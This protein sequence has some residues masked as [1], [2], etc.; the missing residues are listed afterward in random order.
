MKL[1]LKLTDKEKELL[2]K[3]LKGNS[4][5]YKSK[6]KPKIKFNWKKEGF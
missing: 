4:F 5:I 3:M 1:D 6:P 2:K